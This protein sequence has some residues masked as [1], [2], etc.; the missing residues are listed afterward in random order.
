M[1]AAS[2]LNQI[3]LGGSE[4]DTQLC[5]DE[6]HKQSFSEVTLA[7]RERANT[8]NTGSHNP[9]LQTSL[10]SEAAR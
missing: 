4:K 2:K 1:T 10:A 8:A 9:S 7:N 3:Y 6:K 5:E